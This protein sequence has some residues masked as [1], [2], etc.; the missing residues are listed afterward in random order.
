MKNNST[1]EINQKSIKIIDNDENLNDELPIE[2]D[3]S[4]LKEIENPLKKS[5]LIKLDSDLAIHF[6]NSRELNK[7]IRL[8]LK[9]HAII[10]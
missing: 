5:V 10:K 1:K 3:F 8:Q 2:I 4:E 6:K 9:S 7:F